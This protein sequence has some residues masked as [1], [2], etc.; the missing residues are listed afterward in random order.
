MKSGHALRHL[1]SALNWNF[2]TEN[3][4]TTWL[5][6]ISRFKYD[7]YR[8]F[9]AVSRFPEALL[10][11]ICQ[12]EPQHRETAYRL[13]R[14]RLIFLSASEMQQLVSRTYPVF[15]R[16]FLSLL[17]AETLKIPPYLIWKEASSRLAYE[18]LLKRTLF[19]GLSDGARTDGFR[20]ANSGIVANDQVAI[21]YELSEEKWE[22]LHKDLKKRTGAE[23]AK[24]E[25]LFLIDDFTGSGKTLL[26]QENGEWK[27][28]LKKLADLVTKHAEYFSDDCRVAVHHYVGASK[29]IE[30][31]EMAMQKIAAGNGP[32]LWFRTKPIFTFDLQLNDSCSIKAGQVRELDEIIEHYFDETIM[33]D[34]LRIGGSTAKYGFSDCGLTLVMEHNTPNNS[35]ALIWAESSPE[36]QASH[37]MRPLFRRRQRHF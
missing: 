7:S 6:M 15:A 20:R 23:D 37:P 28:K 30:A 31:V 35:L 2:E 19:I 4:E 33:I 14:D 10:S 24:I 25:T 5:R 26:R 1:G 11:W 29:A 9:W 16:R 8:D 32:K 34:S 36:S 13:V 12:F 3:A 27:G 22:D 17:T 21:G 18:N